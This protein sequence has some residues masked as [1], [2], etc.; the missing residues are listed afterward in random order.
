MATTTSEFSNHASP[1]NSRVAERLAPQA[2]LAI[3]R[4]T[5]IPAS[6]K[7]WHHKA[8]LAIT[9]APQ[10]PASQK[11]W[12]HKASLA[13]TRAP[14]AWGALSERLVPPF[15]QSVSLSCPRYLTHPSQPLSCIASYLSANEKRRRTG[16]LFSKWAVGDSNL[17]RLSQQ[18]YSLPS[19]TA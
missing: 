2:R 14:L 8:S 1:A 7:G 6:Q 19:L 11:G 12:H 9:R 4:A 13:P 18:I 16:L 3:T 10:I 17:R 15:L 5:Q